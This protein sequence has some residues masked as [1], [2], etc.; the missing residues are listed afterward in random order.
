MSDPNERRALIRDLIAERDIQNQS[1]LLE[2]LEKRGVSVSQPVLS[3]DLRAL[4]VA[5]QSG[6]YRIHEAERVTP[7]TAL[8]SL[9]RSV[10][11][12]AHFLMVGCEPGAASAVARA[13]E[14]EEPDGLVGT[15]AGDD[16]V[17]VATSSRAAAL[18]VRRRVSD[19]L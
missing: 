6:V 13:L 4:D 10:Q 9:L 12:A 8:K 19:L 14:A 7:L 16:T 3:R 17:L 1:Q 15:L 5:K 2:Q 18:R 11:P